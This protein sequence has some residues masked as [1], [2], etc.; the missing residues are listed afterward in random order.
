MKLITVADSPFEG[1]IC[2]F[3]RSLNKNWLF[4]PLPGQSVA[5]KA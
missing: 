1:A 3:F 4:R 2:Y 5:I